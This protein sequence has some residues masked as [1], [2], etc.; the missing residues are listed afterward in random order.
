[1][2]RRVRAGWLCG[3]KLWH[4]KGADTSSLRLRW[5]GMPAKKRTS[6][7]VVS[8]AIASSYRAGI[9]SALPHR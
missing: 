7:R 5:Q 1:M 4:I 2:P 9:L 8:R 3:Q 6:V